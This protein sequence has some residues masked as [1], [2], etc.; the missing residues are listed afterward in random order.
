M[1][2]REGYMGAK[3][4]SGKVLEVTSPN[5]MEWFEG[6]GVEIER[7]DMSFSVSTLL[8]RNRDF[9]WGTPNGISSFLAQ[10]RN[11]LS[12]SFWRMVVEIFKFKNHALKY[13][14]DLEKNPDLD[15]NETLGQFISV[16]GYSKLFQDAYLIPMCA[17]LWSYPSQG[18]L[19]LPASFVLSYCR[20]NHLLELFGRPQWH[21]VKGQSESFMNKVREELKCM[22][23]QI[24][25]GCEVKS[26][27]SLEGGYKVLE[28]DGSEEMYDQIMFSVPAPDALEILGAEATHDEL[29]ILGAFHYTNSLHGPRCIPPPGC[30]FDATEVVGMECQEL[31][32]DNKQGSNIGSARPFLV[33][34]NP[35]RVPDHVLHKWNTSHP[36]PSVAATKASL[37]LSYI[38]GKRGLWFCGSYQGYGFHEDSVK[39]AKAAAAGLLGKKCDLLMNPKVM[40]PSWTEAGAR[41]VVARFLDQYVSVGGLSFM[42]S[43]IEEGGTTFSFGKA[44]KKCHVKSVMQIHDPRFYWKIAT[45]ADLG[46]ADAYINGY[47][48]FPHQREGLL[49]LFLILI[50]NRDVHKS[51]TNIASKR[52]N[53]VKQ[54]RRNISKHYDLSNDFFA[55]FLDPT[56][57]YSSGIFKVE[58]E[59]L[60]AAQLRK[61]RVLID[62]A[63]V[64]RDHHVLE[65]GSGW[66]TLAIEVVKRTRCK[67]TGITLSEEQLKYAQRKVKE[68]GL[69]DHVTFLLCDY[70]HIPTC[71]KYDRIISC[72]MIEHVGHE[73]MNGFF[74]SCEYHLAEDGLFVLQFS[75]IPEERYDEYRRSSDFI[76]EYIFPGACLP[77]LARVTSAMSKASRLCIEHVENIG[78]HYYPTLMRWMDNL[79]DNRD[80]VL[81][82]GFDDRFIRTWEY[83]FIYS[84]AGFKSRTLGNYQIVFSRP[85]NDKLPNYVVAVL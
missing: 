71:H 53:T 41:L 56:M 85:G 16:Y 69:E 5:M 68:A 37:E 67:Y 7:S 54:S 76:K 30:K 1:P 73:Y 55:L 21:T 79:T 83:Y 17:Y 42:I 32:G 14:E 3:E 36:N 49:N 31:S 10:K 40:V 8:D 60:E 13:L 24:K 22:G 28:V 39:A 12:P 48:S 23:C 25:T 65:I 2:K 4:A 45:E 66:G 19:G 35:T 26:V 70:R 62:K 81:A 61:V 46:L 64:E 59:S 33:T 58:D 34:L 72:E 38:Q 47:F 78:Y 51:S 57:N 9:E 6:L 84:A 82:L 15:H 29:R 11:S 74:S 43:L 75:S 63:N 77:S 27:S 50:A 52:K 20:D 18:V 44:C 80:K